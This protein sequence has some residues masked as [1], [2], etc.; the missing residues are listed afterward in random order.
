VLRRA[1]EVSTRTIRPLVLRA[2]LA[3]A[4]LSVASCGSADPLGPDDVIGTWAGST[5]Q[6]RDISFVVSGGNFAEGTFSY[7][8]PGGEGCPSITGAVVIQGG[9]AVPIEGLEFSI[10]RT[11]IGQN[12]FLTADGTFTSSSQANGTFTVDDR[13]CVTTIGWTASKL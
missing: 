12:T 4:A 9:P 8:L 7:T 10:P 5:S 2:A 13:G 6:E 11:Q 1:P 3:L